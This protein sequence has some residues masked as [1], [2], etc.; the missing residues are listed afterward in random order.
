LPPEI[1]EPELTV[2]VPPKIKVP[3]E[4][5][6]TEPV[7]EPVPPNESEAPEKSW[8]TAKPV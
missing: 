1:V 8:A 5:T 4:L 2:K 3:L 6:V 7:Y